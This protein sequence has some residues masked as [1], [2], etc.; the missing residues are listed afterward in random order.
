[1]ADPIT[2]IGTGNILGAAT[3]VYT[4]VIGQWAFMIGALIIMGA[5]YLKTQNVT[6]PSILGII[7]FGSMVALFPPEGGNIALLFLI[8]S[9]AAAL[10]KAFKL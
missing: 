2:L 5:I 3:A 9:V 6:M 10:S 7:L 4:N 8:L 1:M